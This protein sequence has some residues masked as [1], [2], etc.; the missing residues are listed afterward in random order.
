M[1]MAASGPRFNRRIYDRRWWSLA[2]RARLAMTTLPMRQ[3]GCLFNIAARHTA[4]VP[5]DI[6][7]VSNGWLSLA[8]KAGVT[9]R[10]K[11]GRL[12]ITIIVALGNPTTLADIE[13][14]RPP[15][16]LSAFL[17]GINE[18]ERELISERCAEGI[19]RAKR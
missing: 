17:A 11:F 16:E 4:L 9:P 1:I 19:E 13:C 12:M 5:G 10:S 6:V 14:A 7:V 8:R 3:N 2:W 15:A 18:F